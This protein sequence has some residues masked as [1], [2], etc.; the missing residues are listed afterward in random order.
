MIQ[1]KDKKLE[2]KSDLDRSDFPELE[3]VSVDEIMEA[4]KIRE[5][6][7]LFKAAALRYLDET[8]Y[9]P[10]ERVER[11]V[12]DDYYRKKNPLIPG[13]NW[14]YVAIRI[15]DL[16]QTNEFCIKDQKGINQIKLADLQKSMAMFQ[17]DFPEIAE[18]L[19]NAGIDLDLKINIAE[20]MQAEV[21]QSG[22]HAKATLQRAI[23][24]RRC[25]KIVENIPIDYEKNR[26]K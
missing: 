7:N 13:L 26:Y 17:A 22:L 21:M 9:L 10:I 11:I 18:D 20:V 1:I 15:L 14:D 6:I 19:T 12:N 3:F 5:K 23:I 8:G 24:A 2:V 4:N 16:L 25:M